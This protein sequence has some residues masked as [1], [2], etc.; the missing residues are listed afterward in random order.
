MFYEP[1]RPGGTK[2]RNKFEYR[3]DKHYF[4]KKY[5]AMG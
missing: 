3:A 2:W 5:M 4:M 1:F